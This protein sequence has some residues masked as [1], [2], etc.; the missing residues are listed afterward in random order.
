MIIGSIMWIVKQI[1]DKT[2]GPSSYPYPLR[3]GISFGRKVERKK[4]ENFKFPLEPVSRSPIREDDGRAGGQE[5][6]SIHTSRCQIARYWKNVPI[7]Y[8][9]CFM[10][11][12]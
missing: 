1:R 12:L 2:W 8:Y 11:E 3:K 10:K 6:N 4:S 9:S 7:K 5:I